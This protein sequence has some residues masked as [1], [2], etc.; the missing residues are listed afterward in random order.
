MA[1]RGRV[2][3]P[4][5]DLERELVDQLALLRNACSTYDKGLEAIGRHIALSLRVLLHQHGQSRALLDQLGLRQG[6]FFDS[7]GPVHKGNLLPECTLV[8]MRAVSSGGAYV[9]LIDGGVGGPHATMHIPF[10]DWWNATV[11]RDDRGRTFCRRDLVLLV[12]NT[13]GGAHV[14][15][16]LD[17]AYLSLSRENALGWTF[18]TGNVT[19]AFTGRPELACMRQIAHEVLLT[20]SASA[21]KFREHAQ[22]VITTRAQGDAGTTYMGTATFEQVDPSNSR[23]PRFP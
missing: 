17:E 6:K 2:P 7:A 16:E 20:L 12:A 4:K 9:P 22:P 1:K 14:D 8:L 5:G 18:C 11:C 10:V 19:S 3:R 13:D 21:P 23:A 15:P